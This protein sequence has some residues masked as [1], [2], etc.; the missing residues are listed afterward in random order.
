M[1]CLETVG[2]VFG[3]FKERNC[4]LCGLL[5]AFAPAIELGYAGF[6]LIENVVQALQRLLEVGRVPEDVRLGT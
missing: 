2:R 1:L 5:V 4:T 3:F 6:I